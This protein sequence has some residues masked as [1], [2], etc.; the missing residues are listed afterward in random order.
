MATSTIARGIEP[1]FLKTRDI[2]NK[3]I[4]PYDI[5]KALEQ[6]IRP[7][8]I[9]GA[10]RIGGIWRLY[11]KDKESRTNVI[12]KKN[13][14]VAGKNIP[15]Y[16]KNPFSTMQHGPDDKKDKLTIKNVPLSVSNEEIQ[17]MLQQNNVQLSSKVKYSYM[18]DESGGLTS[19]RNGDRFVYC[20]PF[21][22]PIPVKQKVGAFPCLV[23]HH[24]KDTRLCRSCNRTGHKPG[25]DDCPNRAEPGTILAFSSFRHPLSNHYPSPLYL[26]DE[27]EP[28]PTVEHAMF[29]KMAT[30]LGKHELAQQIKNARHA[31]IAKDLSKKMDETDRDQW[32][33]D[34][35]D[36]ISDILHTKARTC[37]TFRRTL[38]DNRDKVLVECTSNQKWASGLPKHIT[39]VTKPLYYPGK[40]MLGALLMDISITDLNRYEAE[41]NANANVSK[42]SVKP[43]EKIEIDDTVSIADSE[44]SELDEDEDEKDN[45]NHAIKDNSKLP[46]TDRKKVKKA[47]RKAAK[48]AQKEAE[49]K[50]LDQTMTVPC[51]SKSD[52]RHYVDPFSGK[53]KTT[54]STPEKCDKDKLPRLA[55]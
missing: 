33:N 23:F 35:E 6:I 32:E 50:G 47:A 11:I 37:A 25:S 14:I 29:W 52:F 49:A 28:F 19:Y 2:P 7:T 53:R 41:A 27:A 42:P 9:D 10:Q 48:K 1:L 55:T 46:S 21:D 36:M 8:A 4:T 16:D 45:D 31:G 43:D 54:E 5:C 30:D 22:P 18:R 17:K 39:E 26:F 3:D 44:I 38:I 24:G 15:I 34:H 20:E 40:N 13:I 12:V 51:Q